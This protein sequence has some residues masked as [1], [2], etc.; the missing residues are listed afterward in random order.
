MRLAILAAFALAVAGCTTDDKQ[1]IDGMTYGAGDAIAANTVMQMVDPW[2][3]GV[4]HT[5]L[6]VPSERPAPTVVTDA[7]APSETNGKASED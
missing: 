3:D 4:Q 5:N 7:K 1:R 6:K 2:Q